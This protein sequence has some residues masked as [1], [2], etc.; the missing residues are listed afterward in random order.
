MSTQGSSWIAF[1]DHWVRNKSLSTKIILSSLAGQIYQSMS[2][3]TNWGDNGWLLPQRLA[4]YLS[5]G[6]D[7]SRSPLCKFIYTFLILDPHSYPCVY[8]CFTVIITVYPPIPEVERGQ[9][10]ETALDLL[11]SQVRLSQVLP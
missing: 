10:G 8:S 6:V 9:Q 11:E 3:R 7:R 2:S 5:G 4:Q 1:K